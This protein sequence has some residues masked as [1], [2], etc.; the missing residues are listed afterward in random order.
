MKKSYIY[1]FFVLFFGT[2]SKVFAFSY[3]NAYMNVQAVLTDALDPNNLKYVIIV[4][5]VIILLL[6]GSIL[7][8]MK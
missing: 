1:F 8:A 6:I 2:C 5:I 7:F 4:M 3:N